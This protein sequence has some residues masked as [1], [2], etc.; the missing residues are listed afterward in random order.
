MLAIPYFSRKLKK[1][2]RE[3]R[4]PKSKKIET[5]SEPTVNMTML[6]HNEILFKYSVFSK[7]TSFA[8][9]YALQARIIN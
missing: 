9:S 5:A 2:K 6:F 8:C 3:E 7:T 4:N 1:K